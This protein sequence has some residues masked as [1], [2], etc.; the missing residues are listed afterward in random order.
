[1]QAV[2]STTIGGVPS[3][4]GSERGTTNWRCGNDCGL[5]RVRQAAPLLSLLCKR[6]DV[7]FMGGTR[8]TRFLFLA[9]ILMCV[10]FG[11]LLAT[12]LE[13]WLRGQPFLW[14]LLLVLLFALAISSASVT[15][16]KRFSE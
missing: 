2:R 4:A 13:S 5:L 12:A 3:S 15:L 1:L 8:A 16:L 11:M 9:L 10:S 6:F 7:V 14:W